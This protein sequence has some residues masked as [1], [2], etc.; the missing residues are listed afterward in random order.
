MAWM[1]AVSTAG[2]EED[3]LFI[4]DQLADLQ[5]FIELHREELGVDMMPDSDYFN[6]W[7]LVL[8]RHY[9]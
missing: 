2:R 1:K 6:A 4:A 3:A 8:I 5:S 7:Q 9:Q